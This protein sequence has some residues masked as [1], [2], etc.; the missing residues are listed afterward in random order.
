MQAADPADASDCASVQLLAA[1]GASPLVGDLAT[2]GRALTHR[3]VE[4]VVKVLAG[5][6]S[7]E[8]ADTLFVSTRTVENHLHRAYQTLGIRD[9]RKGLA[10]RF[11]WLQ[12]RADSSNRADATSTP[13]IE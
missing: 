4:I 6:S 1:M 8:V 3:Q 13:V 5:A 7:E 10:D 12:T 11:G 2:F 9:G